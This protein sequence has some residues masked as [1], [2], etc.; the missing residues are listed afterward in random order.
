MLHFQRSGNPNGA[1]LVLS[2]A[3]GC[4]L[5]MFDA[6][7]ELLGAEFDILRHDQLGHGRSLHG[8]APQ[9]YSIFEMADALAELIDA[10]CAGGPVHVAGVSLGGMTTQALAARHPR[11]VASITVANSAQHYDAP[12]RAMWQQR[13]QTVS[14]QGM[15]SLADGAMQRWFSPAYR[16]AH[17]GVVDQ[18]RGML[19]SCDPGGYAAC[20]E[21]IMNIDF[22]LSNAHLACPALVIAGSLDEATPPA[23]SQAIAATMPH[24]QLATL[25]TAHLSALEAPAEFAR[26]LAAF[27]RQVH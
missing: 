17:A 26:E 2:H 18:A 20:C 12:A 4:N 8:A 1:T 21:A 7:A 10:Q 3:L 23:M 13:V 9:A 22:S 27:L 24:A 14:A 5:H 19:L 25:P 6:A 11:L 15:A 16:A